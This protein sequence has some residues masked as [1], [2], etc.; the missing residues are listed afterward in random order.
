Q[1]AESLRRKRCL[2]ETKGVL[3]RS[4]VAARGNQIAHSPGPGTRSGMVELLDELGF[5]AG[6][7]VARSLGDARIELG[8]TA[9][10]RLEQPAGAV[11][12]QVRA[13]HIGRWLPAARERM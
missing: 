6:Q 1:R 4:S 9:R 12:D 5:R 7:D 11:D 2:G 8:G 3:E 13:R 10:A